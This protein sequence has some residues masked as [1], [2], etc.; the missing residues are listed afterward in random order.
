MA[1][2]RL[3]GLLAVCVSITLLFP[4]ALAS[5]IMQDTDEGGRCTATETC[6]LKAGHEGSCETRA[7]DGPAVEPRCTQDDACV[8][9]T[10]EEGCPLAASEQT[11]MPSQTNQVLA[12]PP[13]P[14]TTAME[15]LVE[16][17]AVSITGIQRAITGALD[18]YSEDQPAGDVTL[19][20]NPTEMSVKMFEFS[21]DITYI[22]VPTDKGITSFTITTTKEGATD[23]S[24][25]V[26]DVSGGGQS[27]VFANGIP[28]VITGPIHLGGDIYGGGNGMDTG[29]TSITYNGAT[30]GNDRKFFS[31]RTSIHG[32]GLDANVNGSTTIFVQSSHAQ[33]TD[34][35]QNGLKFGIN[36]FVIYGGGNATENGKT[37]N[38]SGNTNIILDSPA[39]TVFGGGY[40]YAGGTAQVN[41]NTKIEVHDGSGILKN[42]FG[43]GKALNNQNGGQGVSDAT[44]KGTA[45]IKIDS[46]LQQLFYDGDFI[47]GGGH[48]EMMTN[49]SKPAL[50]LSAIA[51]VGSVDIQVNGNIVMML[52]N[53]VHSLIGG[54]VVDGAVTP[55]PN[56]DLGMDICQANVNGDVSITIADNVSLGKKLVGGGYPFAGSCDVAGT[57][58][59][60][61]GDNV[62]TK[63]IVG[64]GEVNLN[65]N[66][67]VSADV[68]NVALVIGDNVT[69]TGNFV[70]GGTALASASSGYRSEGS[71]ANVTGN[72]STAIGD[73]FTCQSFYGG[74]YAAGANSHATVGSEG[75]ESK[76]SVLFLGSLGVNSFFGAGYAAGTGRD[77]T[78][79]GDMEA[80]F[81]GASSSK[82]ATLWMNIG[83]YSLDITGDVSVHIRNNSDLQKCVVWPAGSSPAASPKTVGGKITVTI[84]GGSYCDTVYGGGSNVTVEKTEIAV[85]DHA[86]VLNIYGGGYQTA[87]GAVQISLID[88]EVNGYVYPGGYS[89]AITKSA[90]IQVLGDTTFKIWKAGQVTEG[91]NVDIGDGSTGTN[92]K[93][94]I[95]YDASI[96]QVHVTDKA[97]LT[98]LEF[99]TEKLLW[100]TKNVTVDNGGSL[101][102]ANQNET[103]SGDF[104]GGGSLTLAADTTLR[105]GGNAANTTSVDFTS[106]PSPGVVYITAKNSSTGGFT[107][108]GAEKYTLVKELPAQSDEFQWRLTETQTY[109]VTVTP[110][111]NGAIS[112][113]GSVSVKQGEAQ[114]FSFSPDPGYRLESVMVDDAPVLISNNAYTFIPEAN[115]TLSASFVPLTPDD[116]HHQIDSLPEIP[117][118][119]TEEEKKEAINEI[120]KAKQDYEA[121]KDQI[122]VDHSKI[123]DLHDKL[124]QLPTIEI[125]VDVHAEAGGSTENVVT[126]PAS[127]TRVLLEN[128]T[129]NEAAAIISGE[130]AKYEIV[131]TVADASPTGDA[132]N[133]IQGAL[134]G[135]TQAKHYD[136]AVQKLVTR[137]AQDKPAPEELHELET[138]VQM[139]FAI[140]DSLLQAPSGKTRSFSMLRTHENVTEAVADED[141]NPATYTISSDK[142]SYYT[143]VYQDTQNSSGSSGGHSRPAYSIKVAPPM[144]NGTV[145]VNRQA[146]SAGNTITITVTPSDGYGLDRLL[147]TDSKS[148]ELALTS[149]G[150]GTYTFKMPSSGVTIRASFLPID[151]KNGCQFS[152]DCV[153]HQYADLTDS[154]WYHQAVDFVVDHKLMLG[155]SNTVFSPD[156]TT[157][158]AMLVTILYRLEGSPSVTS[159]APYTDLDAGQ[160]YISAVAWSDANR[161]ITGYGDG[162]FGPNDPVTREQV[163]AILYRFASRQGLSTAGFADLSDFP[164]AETVSDYAR[165]AMGWA[166]G[167]GLITGMED[168]TLQPQGRATRAQIAAILMRYCE[169]EKNGADATEA[170]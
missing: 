26:L 72:I 88:A 69:C 91:V 157:T 148:N 62:Q 122:T 162:R 125:T 9:A 86:R 128:M 43:G 110:P 81:D 55:N 56:A 138:P 19:V 39:V 22:S 139:I 27:Y 42:V 158:R 12:P 92:A 44:V 10:H 120:L 165:Q 31:N 29:S 121:M 156:A 14:A 76:V 146:S 74:G 112:P 68:G 52:N 151:E 60:S 23:A 4:T 33:P 169:N 41:G 57:V 123:D 25:V 40:A 152:E 47:I 144:E 98:H 89:T 34:T 45:T 100:N 70:G 117:T 149:E 7:E 83:G 155:A 11:G 167:S 140:P 87:V 127:Q 130:I 3:A 82:G 5:E 77:A 135:A 32:G 118:E 159:S 168:G 37:A 111:Q 13:A 166:V 116:L 113:D 38:V 75:A 107:Y 90:Q 20:L 53:T 103:I 59:I 21:E 93:A 108:G 129:G 142:F 141:N 163:A 160:Y 6:I 84:D 119:G 147:V 154:A 136:V 71:H 132:A 50:N 109:T 24:P 115:C 97:T 51:D 164:D 64:G 35:D 96:N 58:R 145:S 67:V 65:S 2:R 36:S 66:R 1:R 17:S 16:G 124:S 80:V 150:G 54:G 161:I 85:L 94:Y 15:I 73:G 49:S 143:L 61:I 8:A 106:T 99:G 30:G 101:V 105:V 102:I 28:L 131:L 46:D 104:T 126:I 18:A 114:T 137:S 95:L 79:Y 48:G 78:V 153:V 170:P 63:D 133:S 134:N